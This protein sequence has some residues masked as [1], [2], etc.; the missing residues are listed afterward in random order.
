MWESVPS[1]AGDAYPRHVDEFAWTVI[2]SAA[3]VVGAAAAI[4]FGLIPL[5]QS[6]R[7]RKDVPTA[8]GEPVAVAV[9]DDD[10]PVLV[11]EIPQEPV[12]F[13][14]RT[15]LLDGLDA[16]SPS[17][18]VVVVR[19]MTGMRGVGKTQLTAEYARARLEQRWRL[20]AWVNAESRDELL[21]GL[22]AVAAALGLQAEDRE[23][24]GRA[25]RHWLETDGLRC[26][27]VFDNAPTRRSCGLS[28][29]RPGPHG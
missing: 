13:Q 20:V 27:V 2:G 22:A 11:G 29:R 23:A 21:T 6:R 25:V 8:A 17:G 18:R 3:G 24:A 26:V 16:S 1:R 12:A 9:A 5:L 14:P 7:E 28:C 4:V 19:A 15:G 10:V